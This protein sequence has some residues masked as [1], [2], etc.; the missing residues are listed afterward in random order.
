MELTVVAAEQLLTEGKHEE[1]MEA[2]RA[3]VEFD[4]GNAS[5]WK[6][7]GLSQTM[8]GL[9]SEGIESCRKAA[10]LM[11][12]G[13]EFRYALGYALGAD[14]RYDEAIR[15]L[16]AAVVLNP[17]DA[18]ARQ[19]LIYCLVQHGVR[20]ASENPQAAEDALE[21]AHQLDPESPH[22][23]APLLDFYLQRKV[24]N[25]SAAI[26][27]SIPVPNRSHP[28]LAP[29]IARAEAD[30]G[31]GLQL[32]QAEASVHSPRHATLHT[33]AS[34][35]SASASATATAPPPGALPSIM[36]QQAQ[37]PNCKMTISSQAAICPHCDFRIRQTGT[38]AGRDVGPAHNWQD[39]ALTVIS[40]IW[41]IDAAANIFIAFK[42]D[43]LIRGF[44]MGFGAIRLVIGIGLLLRWEIVMMVA[45]FMCYITLFQGALMLVFGLAIGGILGVLAAIFTLAVAGFLIY[46]INW[47]GD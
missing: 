47:A 38:F 37:C 15:E 4:P 31:V 7:L 34:G 6:G 44:L 36:P 19:G 27:Q 21:R 20:S 35:P 2:F 40:I 41:I 26:L 10:G 43:D 30:P 25:R 17:N 5:A 1:A 23:I 11:P 32:A 28:L 24:P 12:G 13:G 16:D 22:T 42:A 45:K 8:S 29:L 39:I 18:K 46:L 33:T 3:I 9:K 14:G